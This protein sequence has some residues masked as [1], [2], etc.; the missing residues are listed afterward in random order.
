MVEESLV[1]RYN[2]ALKALLKDGRFDELYESYFGHMNDKD[3]P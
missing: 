2:T 1:E 3:R